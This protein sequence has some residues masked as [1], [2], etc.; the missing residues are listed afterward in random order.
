MRRNT[1][2]LSSPS[3]SQIIIDLAEHILTTA[4]ALLWIGRGHDPAS[5][6]HATG[7]ALDV[8]ASTRVD[9]MPTPEQR[10][11]GDQL[12]AWLIRH[13]DAL[14]IR[15]IIWQN[16]IWKT[17]YRRSG[18][19]PLP[20]PRLSVSARHLDHVHVFLQDRAG[21]LPADPI[22]PITERTDIMASIDDLRAVIRDELHRSNHEK[23]PSPLRLDGDTSAADM[24][25]TDLAQQNYRQGRGVYEMVR[26]L[27][28]Q[29]GELAKQIQEL[30][31]LAAR[32]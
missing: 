7:R 6:E 26:A 10:A 14:H 24:S 13:A 12:V 31:I 5:N 2:H 22:T 27:Q 28:Q 16:R 11:A 25:R 23:Y 19:Q 8:I 30:T 21:T 4:S 15:H 20:G 32:Q 9:T 1:K 3:T 18:W 29:V 17:R